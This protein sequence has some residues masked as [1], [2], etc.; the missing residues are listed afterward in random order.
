MSASSVAASIEP[1]LLR[2]RDEELE[3]VD[4]A[5]SDAEQQDSELEIKVSLPSHGVRRRSP[6]P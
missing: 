1:A 4:S 5:V 3:D 6:D 2:V